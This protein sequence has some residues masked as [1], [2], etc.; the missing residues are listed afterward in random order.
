LSEPVSP[1]ARLAE[2]WIALLFGAAVLVGSQLPVLWAW[3]AQWKGYYPHLVFSGALHT[4]AEETATYLGWMEQAREGRFLFIDRLTHEPH[5]RQY[6]NVLFASMGWIAR[7]GGTSVTTVYA[8][9]RPVLGA[10]LLFL[11]YVL[12]ARLFD[13][14][15]VTCRAWSGGPRR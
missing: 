5:A 12:A 14:P 7:L 3:R 8:L 13:R 1:R 11:L 10:L 15:A 6:V 4:Y 9:A 2:R